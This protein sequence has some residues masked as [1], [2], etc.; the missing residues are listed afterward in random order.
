MHFTDW[1]VQARTVYGPQLRFGHSSLDCQIALKDM[2]YLLNDAHALRTKDHIIRTPPSPVL[3]S[4]YFS[5]ESS[6]V[7]PIERHIVLYY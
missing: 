2:C 3:R 1:S 5:T 6:E 4:L 7:V